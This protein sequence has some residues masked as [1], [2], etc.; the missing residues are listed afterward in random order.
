MIRSIKKKA[1]RARAKAFHT[2]MPISIQD[3]TEDMVMHYIWM[4]MPGSIQYTDEDIS[5]LAEKMIWR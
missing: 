4:D 3:D 2:G 1:R 5:E